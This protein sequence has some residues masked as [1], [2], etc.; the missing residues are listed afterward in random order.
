MCK[1]VACL[2]GEN[3]RR[4]KGRGRKGK[5]GD[6][7]KGRSRQGVYSPDETRKHNTST[8]RQFSVLSGNTSYTLP[9]HYVDFPIDLAVLVEVLIMPNAM[10]SYNS[11]HASSFSDR[12]EYPS[13]RLI[14]VN[15]D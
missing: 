11:L 14:T 1:C 5:K 12:V 6:A 10:I 9:P 13:S 15:E 3:F 2:Y 4:G 7:E 8:V